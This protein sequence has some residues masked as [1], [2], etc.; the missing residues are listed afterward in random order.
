ME[1]IKRKI[2]KD[3]QKI[4]LNNISDFL[5]KSFKIKTSKTELVIEKDV[6]PN[7]NINVVIDD[8]SEANVVEVKKE[9]IKSSKKTL[10]MTK[11]SIIKN[12]IIF[13]IPIF[14]S[15]LL[16]TLYNLIDSIIVGNFIG[17]EALAAVSS[18]GNLIFLFTS[19]FLGASQGA[20]VL[21][22]K[23]YGSKSFNKMNKA[24]H[25]NFTL[26]LFSS[27]ILTILGVSLTPQLLVLMNTDAKVLPDSISYFRYYFIGCTGIIMFNVLS[28]TLNALG[29]SRRPLYYLI[30][31]SIVNVLLDLLFIGLLDKDVKFAAI[32]T[33]ISQF[34]SASL[35]LIHLLKTK[36]IYQLSFT[37]LNIDFNLVKSI[38]KFGVPT[39]VQNSVIGLANVF[40]QSNINTFGEDAM[41]GCGSY[42]KLESFVFLPINAFTMAIATFVSQNLGAKE[43]DRAKKGARF[44]IITSMVMAEA[45]GVMF[46]FSSPYLIQIFNDDPDV[47]RI[48][49]MQSQTTALFFFL[50]AFSHA[51][52]S[53][54]R[55]SGKAFV[56]MLVML[57]FWCLVR[58]SYI[59]IALSISN[60][61][62]LIFW[63]YPITWSLSSIVYLI[64]YFRSDWVHNFDRNFETI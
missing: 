17:K 47:I 30:F 24:I 41:A 64:Y 54:A 36:G 7:C 21:I 10:D 6:Y 5:V 37:R 27:I 42:S 58:V 15:S 18:S 11:N 40:V 50:L 55:G 34:L 45:F 29:N 57:T 19:F 43:Y 35:C 13:A 9:T 14:L 46:Y 22:S 33:T 62:H 25:T 1:I 3:R 2:L 32:A 52:A 31:S 56:P 8:T 20:G 63:A 59:Y 53:V 49:V 12:M 39:G 38:L 48:G 60:D 44:G 51:I 28:G 26:G 61:I 4:K 23:L 16:Q